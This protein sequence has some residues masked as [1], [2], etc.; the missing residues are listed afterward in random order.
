MDLVEHDETIRSGHSVICTCAIAC[1]SG[2]PCL[3]MTSLVMRYTKYTAR[4]LEVRSVLYAKSLD[5]DSQFH[6]YWRRDDP[7][8]R[9]DAMQRFRCQPISRGH[10]VRAGDDDGTDI[11]TQA[12]ANKII[13]G[14]NVRR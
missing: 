6:D 9:I 8:C 5:L 13:N 10:R 14:G 1:K 3:H 2:I 11:A 12:V 7:P 4:N